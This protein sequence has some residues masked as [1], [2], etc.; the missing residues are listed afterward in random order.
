VT[1]VLD[2][3]LLEGSKFDP[4]FAD[5]MV[6]AGFD[7]IKACIQC[8]TCTGSCPSGRRTAL[9][10]RQLIRRALLGLRDE[11]LSDPTLWL[12]TTC[13]TCQERCPRKISV[14]EAIVYLRNLSVQAG[15]L[16]PEHK[17]ASHKLCATGHAV[18]IDDP[19]WSKMRQDLGLSKLP[20]TVHS[21]PKALREV[22]ILLRKTGFDKLVQYEWG[23]QH[24]KEES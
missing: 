11:V 21:F 1:P 7:H 24:G 12:C 10:T 6:E 19:K 17:R 23:D 22:Q 16:L 8:G 3:R 5:Q 15:H 13:G 20:P 18:P 4:S 9:R 2:R 14:T